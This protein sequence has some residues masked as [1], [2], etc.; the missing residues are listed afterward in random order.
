MDYSHYFNIHRFDVTTETAAATCVHN[1]SHWG[2]ALSEIRSWPEY[3]PQPLRVLEDSAKQMKISK[4]YLKD[5]SLRFGLKLGS[6]KAFGAPYAV[7]RI[8]AEAVRLQTS[9][10][11][12]SDELRSGRYREITQHV[13]V[14]VATDG[15]Q[16]RGLA[17]GAKIFGCQCVNYIHNRVSTGR[18]KMMKDLGAVVI[19]VD[20]EYEASIE[21][22]KEDARMNGWHFVSSTSWSDFDNGIPQNVMNA[23]M[24]VIEEA[25]NMLQAVEKTTHVLVC[26]GVGSIAAALFLGFFTHYKQVQ[27]SHAGLPTKPPCFIVIEPSEAD[28]LFQSAKRGEPRLSEGSLHT[29]MARLGYSVSSVRHGRSQYKASVP[30]FESVGPK[31]YSR[32]VETA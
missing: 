13:T 4:L 23:Y 8:L 2:D 5:E 21:R 30:R 27:E 16:G 15:N 19:R 17:Y 12:T 26:G 1:L 31:A 20:G 10:H 7:Y 6:F 25:L 24:L 32:L 29:L 11:T 28:Y 22:A 18:A 3:E 14:C 9:M